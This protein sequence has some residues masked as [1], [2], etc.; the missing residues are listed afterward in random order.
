MVGLASLKGFYDFGLG[1]SLRRIYLS[2]IQHHCTMGSQSI[3]GWARIK[4]RGELLI[5]KSSWWLLDIFLLSCYPENRFRTYLILILSRMMTKV[6][7]VISFIQNQPTWAT[8]KPGKNLSKQCAS[9]PPNHSFTW[10]VAHGHTK[11]MY[12]L[13][14]RSRFRDRRWGWGMFGF[15]PVFRVCTQATIFLISEANRGI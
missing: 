9:E 1:G 15:F 8:E 14:G 2:T 12:R 6:I 4:W 10:A 7:S 13:Q 11:K 3:I 5:Q